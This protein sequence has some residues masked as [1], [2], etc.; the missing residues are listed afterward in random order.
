MSVKIG[1]VPKIN[2]GGSSSNGAG[3]MSSTESDSEN[4]VG[5]PG[6]VQMIVEPG[7]GVG[8]SSVG[9]AGLSGKLGSM[10]GAARFWVACA[11]VTRKLFAAPISLSAYAMY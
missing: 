8:M 2:A 4:G 3:M 7:G 9:A 6:A 1:V 11:S 5:S 10:T